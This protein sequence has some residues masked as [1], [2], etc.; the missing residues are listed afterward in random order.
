MAN[1]K[2]NIV[3]VTHKFL[4]HPDDELVAFLNEKNY[5][6]ILHICHSFSDSSD[7]KSYYKWYRKGK[8]HQEKYSLDYIKFPEPIIYLKEVFYTYW[9]VLSKRV[10]WD[11]YIGMD[12]LCVIVGNSLKHLGKVKKTIYWAIDFVP[13]NRFPSKFANKIYHMINTHGYKNSDEMW[14]LS[15]RM[16]QARE[17]FLGIKKSEYKKIKVVQYGMWVDRIKKYSYED[18]EKNTLVFMGHIKENQ[19]VQ[20]V[21]KAI[22][23][24]V[25]YKPKFRFKIIGTGPYK[26]ELMKMAEKLNVSAYCNFKGKIPNH[27]DLEVEIAKS[28]LAIAPYMKKLDKWT[29]YADPGK[30]KTYLACGVP[31]LLTDLPWNAENIHAA[32]CGIIIEENT[33]NMVK[34]IL[35]LM[36]GSINTLY[37]KNAVKYAKSYD[38]ET[39]F[40]QLD[41]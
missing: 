41:L 14:D 25:K 37:R 31:V 19:G 26:E 10:R 6:N 30:V 17:K 38:Y 27:R 22:P 4:T 23:E 1:P 18:C 24:I 39:I 15:P 21:L 32:K 11:L 35:T 20:L 13:N 9:W 12:G 7:R 5:D 34:H 40:S 36:K 16:A 3:I 2:Q 29:Y 28:C 33:S 8:L